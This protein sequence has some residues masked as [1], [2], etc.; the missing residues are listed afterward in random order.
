M[1]LESYHEWLVETYAGTPLY[2][3]GDFNLPRITRPRAS[4]A[5]VPYH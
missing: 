3:A 1:A 4:L 5:A 2:I